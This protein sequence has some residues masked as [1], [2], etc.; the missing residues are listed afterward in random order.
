MRKVRTFN[1]TAIAIAAATVLLQA[2]GG[3]GGGGGSGGSPYL[4]GNPYLRTEVPYST[5]VRQTIVDPLVNTTGNGYKWAVADTFAADITGDG[6]QDLIIAGRMTQ[7]TPVSDW[8]NFRLSMLG[9]QDGKLV[10]KTAQWFP[11]E[12]NIILGSEPSV[13]F[14]DF[15]KTGRNDLFLST[16][17]DMQHYGPTY[18]YRNNGT[19][20]ERQ[21]LTTA[22]IWSHDSAIGDLN[23][24]GY[25]D[26]AIID[27][28]TNTTLA[29]NN[30]VNGFNVY[31]QAQNIVNGFT[32][33]A[34][35]TGSS[36]AIGNFL[37][38]STGK[39]QVVVTDTPGASGSNPTK[40]YSW[41]INSSNE[42]NFTELSTLPTPR[43]EL[44]KW[45]GFGFVAGS[46]NV[47]AVT[48]DFN[49]DNVPD[50]LI[51]SRPALGTVNNK[52]S[53][54]Q[55]LKNGGSGTFTDVTDTT[56]VGYNHNTYTTYNPKFLDLNGDGR[57]DI[58]VSSADFTGAN[59]STQFLLK[60]ADGKYV[61]AHQ[62]ILTDFATQ[63][64]S[65]QGADNMGNTVNVLK[66]P[67][68]KL[69]LV[70]AVSFSNNGDRQLAVYMSDLGSQSFTTA[71]S[72]V[73][74]ILQKWPYMT[75]AQAN[76][77]LARTSA[78][79]FGG[80]VL[81]L[82]D[83][84]NPVGS[85]SLST[86]SGLRPISGYIAG[87]NLDSG[88]A[89]GVDQVGRGYNMDIKSM[90]VN[91]INAFGY[92]TQHNDQ[93]E[94]TSHAEYLVNGNL[95][96]VSGMRIGSD[97]SAQDS[98]QLNM[99]NKPRQYTIGVP[100]IYSYG[101]WSMGTQYTYLNANPWIA[102]GGAWGEVTGSGILDNVVTY[103]NRGFSTQASLMNV[104]TN[105][106]PGLITK[107]NN[108]WGAWAETGYRFGDV[109]RE[110]DLGLYAGIKPVVLSGSVEAKLPTA[111]DNAG[112]IMYTN[113]KL[114]LQNQT[115]GY[116]RALYT[117]QL[118][119]QT[120]L[121]LSAMSTTDGQYRAMTEFKFWID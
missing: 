25:T 48:Y 62:N 28:G 53:E 59:N 38:D 66:G 44:A 88:Q 95:T 41:N 119:R 17:T 67:N 72:A 99:L 68:G 29:F 56:L 13:K 37:Q 84:M 82:E 94:L 121:R 76:E 87:V 35:N 85:L 5:P 118:T 42:L 116:V 15:F 34:I 73:N 47:R 63:A 97:Y 22:N 78:T 51:F 18:F 32:N 104:T 120:Q 14:A 33:V 86:V 16:G 77:V 45:A 36:I 79:Y 101:K 19:S 24:D 27:Y 100:K 74:L 6:N 50:V 108:M 61:A 93:H 52:Y 80:K 2:C 70:S 103:R 109:R 58:L 64:N 115:T 4:P 71:Q 8:G 90:A 39:S 98:T 11:N 112:N 111:V 26:I 114:A 23:G 9:W 65:T 7:P 83:L 106:N 60:S 55:F 30:K 54:I 81:S 40:M 46:H 110:G 89:I 49:D 57:E 1:K 92:N 105:I 20:F 31:T 12:S 117:N 107:V 10:D 3:G 43:F 69:Y 91:K 113:K 96:T 75:V 102:F 21:T